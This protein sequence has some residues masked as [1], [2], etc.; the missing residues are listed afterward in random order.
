MKSQRYIDRLQTEGV[1]LRKPK[2]VSAEEMAKEYLRL[3]SKKEKAEARMKELRDELGPCLKLLPDMAVPVSKVD[4]L[5]RC[6]TI[7][8]LFDLTEA[9]KSKRV[10]ETIAPYV[11]T[12]RSLNLKS[13]KA[14]VDQAILK[15]FITE[16]ESFQL[17]TRKRK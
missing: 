7:K 11:K 15:P 6:V 2:V 13:A 10:R 9:E 14:H 16:V 3:K 12:E 4:E 5:Y 8:E 1:P 17:R